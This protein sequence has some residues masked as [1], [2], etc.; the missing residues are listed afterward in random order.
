[1][2]FVWFRRQAVPAYRRLIQ[3]LRAMWLV[4]FPVA[5]KGDLGSGA[6]AP[7]L[8]FVLDLSTT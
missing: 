7:A 4:G 1:M 8:A 2:E 3:Y 5:V 6:E